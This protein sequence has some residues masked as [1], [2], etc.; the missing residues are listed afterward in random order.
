LRE[1]NQ[2]HNKNAG[3]RGVSLNVGHPK[4]LQIAKNLIRQ[5]DIVAEGFSPGVLERLGLGYD[6]LRSI[7]PD[8]IYIQQAGMGGAGRY[9]RFRTVGPIAASFAGATDMSGLPE[10]AMPAGWGYSYLD[11]SGA[12]GCALATGDALLHRERTGEGQWIYFLQ[13][14][15]GIFQTAVTV[16]DEAVG[17]CT[18]MIGAFDGMGR[19]QAVGVPAGVC[20]NAADRCDTDPRYW[21]YTFA[22]TTKFGGSITVPI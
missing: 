8:I 5:S 15:A 20:Q 7:R 12:Y 4:G 3:K 18:A 10:P 11:W 1:C 19:L 21:D 14:E 22:T 16:L 6:V 17:A 2:F 9:G 13:C